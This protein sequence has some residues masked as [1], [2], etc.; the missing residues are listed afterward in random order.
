M[1]ALI[2][3][4]PLFIIHYFLHLLTPPHF[5]TII[6]TPLNRATLPALI[7]HYSL[8]IIHCLPNFIVKIRR[9]NIKKT[10]LSDILNIFAIDKSLKKH[11]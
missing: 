9:K 5:L 3:H 6:D 11:L 2:I 10:H 8:S 4:Y 1:P 7:I